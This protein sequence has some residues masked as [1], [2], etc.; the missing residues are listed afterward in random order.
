MNFNYY[1]LNCPFLKGIVRDFLITFFFVIFAM[2]PFDKI[3]NN[4][5]FNFLN[6]ITSYTGGIYYIHTLMGGFFKKYFKVIQ[7]GNF[8]GCFLIY[9][10]CYSICFFVTFI[11][12]KSQLKY[13]FM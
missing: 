7:K 13:L 11:L 5:I 10:I 4:Y 12:Q 1:S 3:N 2:L 9:L 6:K 8:K